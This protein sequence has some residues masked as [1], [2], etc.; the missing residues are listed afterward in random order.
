MQVPFLLFSSFLPRLLSFPPTP[1]LLRP[2]PPHSPAGVK[3]DCG[4]LL[5]FFS[6]LLRALGLGRGE[7]GGLLNDPFPSMPPDA[8]KR[9]IVFALGAVPSPPSPP[10][11]PPFP[12]WQSLHQSVREEEEEEEEE[13]V[14]K[15][16]A[17]RFSW[18]ER[19]GEA[20]WELEGRAWDCEG[21]GGERGGS[22]GEN[23]N[24]HLSPFRENQEQT[25]FKDLR[26]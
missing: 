14:K 3:V 25:L 15:T 2:V 13:A 17:K 8:W 26:H 6:S 7:G 1:L 23:R 22:G 11:P 20:R 21:I 9:R 16:P 18:Q 12:W 24:R 19:R 5:F 10:R 4:S